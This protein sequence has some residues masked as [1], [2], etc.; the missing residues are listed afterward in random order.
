MLHTPSKSGWPC[1]VRLVCTAAAGEVL[2]FAALGGVCARAAASKTTAAPN[3]NALRTTTLAH[4]FVMGRP[5]SS[6]ALKAD[7]DLGGSSETLSSFISWAACED[8]R[9]AGLRQTLRT[10]TPSVAYS[11][12]HAGTTACSF[13]RAWK[14][15]SDLR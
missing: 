14:I 7:G 15:L 9:T 13:S 12:P 4:F 6:A 3:S 2:A 10:C 5:L 11:F 8:G 1:G